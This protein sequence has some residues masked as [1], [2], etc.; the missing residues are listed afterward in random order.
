MRGSKHTEKK[1][2]E[3]EK[4]ERKKKRANEH[5]QKKKKEKEKEK[6]GKRQQ[7]LTRTTNQCEREQRK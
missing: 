1:A 2:E 5:E 7:E 4:K 3:G 6:Y